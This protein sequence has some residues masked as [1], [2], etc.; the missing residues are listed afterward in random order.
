M[1]LFTM[2]SD[3]VIVSRRKNTIL[4]GYE[5]Y[6]RKKKKRTLKENYIL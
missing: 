2:V 3:V 4:W 5:G 6:L 1:Y